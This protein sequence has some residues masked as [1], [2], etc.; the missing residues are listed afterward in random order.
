MPDILKTRTIDGIEY[1]IVWQPLKGTSQEIA[2]TAPCDEV[3]YCGTRGPGKTITQLMKF[4]M[5]VGLGYGSYWRGVIFDREFKNLGDLEAQSRRFFNQFNDGARFLSSASDYKWVWPTGEELLFRHVKKA[6]DYDNFHGHEYP[7]I[8]WNELTKWPD[9]V[10]YDKMKSTNRCSFDHVNS[11]LP[12][13]PMQI[14]STTNSNGAGKP[15]VK[16]YFINVAEYGEVVKDR[17]KIFNPQT[18]KQEFV[19]KTRVAIFGSYQENKF[20]PPEY[21]AE[22]N[23]IKD[24]NLKRS[25]LLGSWDTSSGGAL[26]DLWTND[27]HILPNFPIPKSWR[28]DRALDW[29][30][31]RPYSIGWFAESNGEEFEYKNE[32]WFFPKGTLIQI[33][34]IYGSEELGSN[35]GTRETPKNV[36]RKIKKYEINLLASGAIKTQPRKGP[37]DNEIGDEK[38]PGEE[39]VA[40]IMAR[41]GVTWLKS[42]K[43]K[44]SRRRR[45]QLLRDRLQSSLEG[46]DPGFY[47]QRRCLA[48]IELLPSIPSDELNPEDVDTDS[49]DHIYD[50]VGYRCLHSNNRTV[51]KIKV[52]FRK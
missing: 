14:F 35:K 36:A 2:I 10:L 26:D 42:D 22:L 25:W 9:S 12:P 8:G 19:N 7:F 37:A 50:M 3:L 38:I 52:K 20:L 28:I 51:E 18:Q 16:R 48:T 27:I 45:L 11:D 4:R 23:R 47:V 33:G 17:V 44:G 46:E 13:V 40:T 43:S 49:E 29:G 15:W 34:E 6:K 31:A 21:I 5:N 1:E 32:I 39:S 41:E 24:K 30:S